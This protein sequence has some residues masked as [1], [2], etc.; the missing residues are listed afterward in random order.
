MSR[1]LKLFLGEQSVEWK[2][3]NDINQAKHCVHRPG[4][5]PRVYARCA[6]FPPLIITEY[7]RQPTARRHLAIYICKMADCALHVFLFLLLF[8]E[9]EKGVKKWIVAAWKNKGKYA[10]LVQTLKETQI[11]QRKFIKVVVI[12]NDSLNNMCIRSLIGHNVQS[13]TAEGAESTLIAFV[14]TRMKHAREVVCVRQTWESEWRHKRRPSW[15]GLLASHGHTRPLGNSGQ[16]LNGA[17]QFEHTTCFFVATFLSPNRGYWCVYVVGYK[18]IYG[19]RCFLGDPSHHAISSLIDDAKTLCEEAASPL[20]SGG[21]DQFLYQLAK[22]SLAPGPHGPS[23]LEHGIYI[24]VSSVLS[25]VKRQVPLAELALQSLVTRSKAGFLFFA[26]SRL[27]SLVYRYHTALIMDFTRRGMRAA[28]ASQAGVITKITFARSP[29]NLF[30]YEYDTLLPLSSST[31]T[32]RT[33]GLM[34]E[35]GEAML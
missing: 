22:S 23:I 2:Q 15:R 12:I 7:F 32:R 13:T 35:I 25:E 33:K 26:R 21:V 19:R 8:Q 31:Y 34:T 24:L 9:P 4:I 6:A 27:T 14:E 29:S 18:F 3:G 11:L 10:N 16:A 5:D 1:I 30:A 17:E 28:L 20:V